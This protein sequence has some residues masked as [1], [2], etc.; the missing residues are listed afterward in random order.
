MKRPFANRSI[1]LFVFLF[2]AVVIYGDVVYTFTQTF[3]SEENQKPVTVKG[4]VWMSDAGDYK[5]EFLP[6][7]NPALGRNI[8]WVSTGKESLAVCE[9]SA[10]TWYP[11]EI[12][13]LDR[14]MTAFNDRQKVTVNSPTA[15]L[16]KSGP[17]TDVLGLKTVKYVLEAGCV[18]VSGEGTE[19]IEQ[20]TANVQEIWVST[21]SPVL[22]TDQYQAMLF[23]SPFPELNRALEPE[24]KNLKGFMVRVRA[25][26]E[27]EQNRTKAHTYSEYLVTSLKKTA[28]GPDFFKVPKGYR[29]VKMPG[30]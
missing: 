5:I 11:L 29:K 28:I 21:E 13:D 1:I 3:R 7:D 27:I 26:M 17:D 9:P 30:L 12:K 23:R 14:N 2:S 10:K 6:S 8:Y 24:V 25:V 16:K 19:K 4:R 18:A 15:S 20:K 22:F